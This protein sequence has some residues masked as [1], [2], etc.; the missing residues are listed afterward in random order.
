[1]A[2]TPPPA[3]QFNS[4]PANPSSLSYVSATE[5]GRKPWQGLFVG[6]ILT[7]IVVSTLLMVGFI[8]YRWHD[9]REPT[10]AVIIAGDA[11]LDGTVITVSGDRVITTS[12]KA[13]NNFTASVLVEPGIYTVKAER[14]GILLLQQQ[15][16]VKRFFGV[17]FSLT[18]FVK[19][20]ETPPPPTGGQ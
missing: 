8:W 3:G 19:H 15:V 2:S 20:V 11:S 9:V 16:D 12:L 1:M 18:D 7:L 10:T 13:S 14:D 6:A 17:Q 4:A 5:V